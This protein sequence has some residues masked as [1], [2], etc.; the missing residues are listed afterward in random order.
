MRLRAVFILAGLVLAAYAAH[1][2]SLL[3]IMR[4][5]GVAGATISPNGQSV[6]FTVREWTPAPSDAKNPPKEEARSHIW[7][8]SATDPSGT[9]AAR[10]ITFGE[11]GESAPAWSPDGEYISFIA[12]RGA[13]P[14]AGS[15]AAPPEGQIYIMHAAG[16]EAREL[17]HG[18]GGMS[19]YSWAPNSRSIAFMRRQPPSPAEEA[20]QK[21]GDDPAVY[22]GD[23]RQTH[24]WTVEVG[25]GAETELTSGVAMTA[26]GAPAWSPDGTQ[27]A[28][29]AAP[30]PIIRDNRTNLFLV[31]V[32]TK[33]VRQLTHG[34]SASTAPAWSPDGRK[35]AYLFDPNAKPAL[36]DGIPFQDSHRLHLMLVDVA[37]ATSRDLASTSFDLSAGAPIWLPDGGH[38]LFATGERVY[39]S[40]FSY[41][42]V[43]GVYTQLTR[44]ELVALN[45]HGTLSRDG[46]RVAFIRQSA[47]EPSDVFASAADFETP[48]KLTTVNPQ[49]GDFALGTE[50]VL[51]WNSPDGWP[52]EGILVKP[53]GYHAG[54]RYPLLLEIHGGP[55]GAF[56]ASYNLEAQFWA[57]KGWAVLFTNPRGSTGYGEKFL[58]G[59]LEDWGG[60]DYRDIMSGVDAAIQRGVADP[61]QLAEWG[62][63]YGGYMTCWVV[64]QTHRFKAAMMGAGLSDLAS[65]YGSTDIPNY[66]AGF[67]DGYPDAATMK[68]YRE[69]SGITYADQ[70][71]TPLLML[72]GAVD[73]R[74][75]ISQSLEFYRALKERGKTVELVFY[76]REHHGFT[77]YYHILNRYQRIYDWM[78]HYTLREPI[79]GVAGR[80][81][82]ASH[83]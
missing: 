42:L 46:T 60:G 1:P 2:V 50:E 44:N 80:L 8:V 27:M 36:G 72:Q 6:L 68:L 49:A 5:K 11:K 16:G 14:A 3:D 79:A 19:A 52:V 25:S 35:I 22:E 45:P 57:G 73:E 48:H 66:L 12:N 33:E 61:D 28:F 24:V 78:R 67:F 74:V 81:Q 39:R 32:A 83:R 30:T 63:S 64:S 51:H 75:P 34:L 54:S 23:F 15:E 4:L 56:S 82:G 77:E 70:V 43:S 55:T 59:N 53:V 65:M 47:N 20:A 9:G 7:L 37:T 26:K 62:W 10:Q 29:E 71:S 18:R 69:R 31:T 13:T 21:R 41:D 58:R 76:P 38:I 17:T 40:V